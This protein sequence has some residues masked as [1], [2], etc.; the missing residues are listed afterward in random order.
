MLTFEIE[1]HEII[2][3]KRYEKTYTKEL[4]LFLKLWISFVFLFAYVIFCNKEKHQE[5]CDNITLR[6]TNI[7]ML[8]VTLENI[9]HETSRITSPFPETSSLTGHCH[10][11]N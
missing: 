8:V 9:F 5:K 4:K 7:Q 2:L 10:H 3:H 11:K 1:N 6:Y